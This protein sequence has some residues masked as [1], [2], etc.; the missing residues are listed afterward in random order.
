MLR[1]C[2]R[3]LIPGGR[4]AGYVIHTSPRLSPALLARAAE[5]GPGDVV[6]AALPE[7]LM[8]RVGFEVTAASDVT[9]SFRVTC[10]ALF[11][12]RQQLADQLRLQE[13]DELFENELRTKEAMLEGIDEGLL[14][15]TLIAGIRREGR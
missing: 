13:G 9:E 8:S 1:E 7:E 15:R 6:A 10:A 12:A 11:R 2:H 3:V 4:I 5:L 14:R